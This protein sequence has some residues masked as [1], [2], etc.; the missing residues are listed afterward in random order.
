MNLIGFESA[1]GGD[2]VF[3]ATGKDANSDSLPKSKIAA[4]LDGRNDRL[5]KS[6]IRRAFK[7]AR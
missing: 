4:H 5:F 1:A 7:T 2:D 3:L 6:W